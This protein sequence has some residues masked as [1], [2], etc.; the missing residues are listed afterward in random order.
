MDVCSQI[1]LK[2]GNL[3][4]KAD[5]VPC[6]AIADELGNARSANIVMTGAAVKAMGDFS[7]ED[8]IAAMNAMFA[9]KG[10]SKF[11]EANKKAFEAGYAAV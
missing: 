5:K 4:I 7:K 8:A 11:E 9:K 2:T 6:S 1:F 10:K 3:K